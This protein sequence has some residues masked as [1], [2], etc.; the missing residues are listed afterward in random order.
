MNSFSH[1]GFG[2]WRGGPYRVP[3]GIDTDGP[4]YRHI[5]IHPQPPTP[6]NNPNQ[7]AINWVE[8]HYDCINGRIASAWKL[9]RGRF[10]LNVTIPP[11]T[12]ASVFLPAASAERVSESGGPV[13]K[14]FGVP[15]ITGAGDPLRGE[16]CAA[17]FHSHS[18]PPRL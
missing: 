9:E 17:R 2:G 6:G 4:G 1:Y 10:T 15:V 16:V 14:A 12:S 8:A 13:S 11:N 3:A 18:P 7:P 5:V